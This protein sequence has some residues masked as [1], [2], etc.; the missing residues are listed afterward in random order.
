MAILGR[1]SYRSERVDELHQP[2][3]RR[4]ET[5]PFQVI[6]HG[7]HGA[8]D[9]LRLLRVRGNFLDPGIEANLVGLGVDDHPPGPAQEP[10]NALDAFHAPGFDGFKRAHEHLVKPQA[11][12]AILRD[13]RVGVDHVAPA[14]G[15]LVRPGIDPDSR[16]LA[17]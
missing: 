13:D 3:D 15:H 10:V 17:S 11:I 16:V 12:S 1:T 14:L 8:G 5:Q 6:G 9:D 4:V 2:A 7:G